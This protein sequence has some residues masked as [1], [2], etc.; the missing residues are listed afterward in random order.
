MAKAPL[1]ICPSCDKVLTSMKSL[2]GHFGRSHRTSIK[3]DRIKFLCPFCD[4]TPEEVFDSTSDLDSHVAESHPECTLLRT[5]SDHASSNAETPKQKSAPSS[6]SP[7]EAP[8]RRRSS[9]HQ[10][11]SKPS[12]KTKP[13]K[14]KYSHPLCKCP[15]CDKVLLP[16]GLFGHF[17]RVH[18]GQLG[19]SARFEWKNVSYACPFCPEDIDS[20]SPHIFRTIELAEAHVSS[21][22]TNCHLTRPNALSNSPKSTASSSKPDVGSSSMTTKKKSQRSS[23]RSSIDAEGDDDDAD[24]S[25]SSPAVATRK[26]QRSRRSLP[27]DMISDEDNKR[28]AAVAE[29]KKC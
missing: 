24:S 18:S 5:H 21:S 15:N 10:A 29:E 9:R 26:S 23:R 8:E 7:T 1:C 13:P 12:S 22:H 19:H 25:S 16:Q 11:D 28:G 27:G 3:Q 14:R 20:G 17:G 2:Y 4:G 6:T